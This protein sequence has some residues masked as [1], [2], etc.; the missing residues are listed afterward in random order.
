ARS[1]SKPWRPDFTC[2]CQ[3]CSSIALS[4]SGEPPQIAPPSM[5]V[6]FLLGWKLKTVRSPKLPMRR[7]RQ[8]E[9]MAWAASSMMRSRCRAAMSYRRSM[10]TGSPAKCTG[11]IARVRSVMAASAC[12]RSVLRE[13]SPTS[14]NT[15]RAPTRTITF[16]VAT[17]LS[18][19]VITSSPG[20][21]PQASSAISRPAV[22]EVSVRTGRPPRY[23]DS[24]ASSCATFGPLASHP[25]RST[26]PTAAMVSSS[27]LGRVK[28]S[29]GCTGRFESFIGRNSGARDQHDTE[30]DDGDASDALHVRHLAE[31]PPG[32]PDVDD[33]AEREQRIC[34]AHRHARQAHSPDDDTQSV[35]HHRIPESGYRQ[36]V[37]RPLPHAG[38]ARNQRATHAGRGLQAELRKR[39]EQDAAD[40]DRK[41]AQSH[42]RLTATV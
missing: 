27:M 4:S 42:K 25:E 26:S 5:V 15:G 37:G 2:P 12:S 38:I 31:Q 22:A 17:K 20:P 39:V 35:G 40:Q 16:A 36:H 30:H 10:S 41:I 28:G 6:M 19:G 23:A 34:L 33:I 7:P 32:E 3:R 18:A 14:T 13:S 29:S 9:P 1:V 24:S 11:M 8:L 21:I